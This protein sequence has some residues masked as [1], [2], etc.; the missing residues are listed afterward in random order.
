MDHV[1]NIF[2]PTLEWA[3]IG[4]ANVFFPLEEKSEKINHSAPSPPMEFA[5]LS[6]GV[7]TFICG[8]HRDRP[9]SREF[10]SWSPVNEHHIDRIHMKT[11]IDYAQSGKW[12]YQ[13][14]AVPSKT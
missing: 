3:Q 11:T 7:E 14:W 4:S 6:Q 8:V 13:H 1:I 2:P 10:E 12:E 9:K 5:S